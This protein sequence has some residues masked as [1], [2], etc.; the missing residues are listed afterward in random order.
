MHR[1]PE[2]SPY[3]AV[4]RESIIGTSGQASERQS[5]WPENGARLLSLLAIAI[6]ITCLFGWIYDIDMLK[7]VGAGLNS[8]KINT[9]IGVIIAGFAQ[10]AWG[11]AQNRAG[12][13]SRHSVKK[14]GRLGVI[15][16]CC[17]AIIAM[18]TLLEYLL[19][20]DFGIDNLWIVD[21]E[22]MSGPFPGRM[23]VAT[24]IALLA[25]ALTLIT[26]RTAFVWVALGI[27]GFALICYLLDLHSIA[28]L[29]VANMAIHTSIA[30][31]LLSAGRIMAQP[32]RGM[33]QLLL[34][35][36]LGGAMARVMLPVAILAP[37]AV[38]W[39][40]GISQR[41]GLLD[42]YLSS[43][44]G[45]IL[46]II[47]L[48]TMVFMTGRA[49]TVI[50]Q[51]RRCAELELRL[52]HNALEAKVRERTEELRQ[53]RDEANGANRHKSVFLAHMSHELRTPLNAILGF[54][55]IMRREQFG[56]MGQR[57]YVSYADDIH[58][59]GSHLL[60]LINDI[61]DLSKIEAGKFDFCPQPILAGSIVQA[62]HDLI[63]GLAKE[64][65]LHLRIEVPADLPS[66]EADKRAIKQILIN[67]LSNAIKF[68]PPGGTVRLAVEG[69][70]DGNPAGRL[71]HLV[72]IVQDTGIGM[73]PPEIAAAQQ[74]FGQIRN[75]FSRSHKGTGLGLFLAKQLTELQAGHLE[76][77][78]MPGLGTT[79]RVGLPL[80][81]AT[82]IH[83]SAER[84]RA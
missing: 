1:R 16:G 51:R 4:A 57:R 36:D 77:D 63:V 69:Q 21:L 5:A 28:R 23:P 2:P 52:S 15:L 59:S 75:Q 48:T 38:S 60:S 19:G 11:Q 35:E 24:A 72:F 39:L 76:I 6:A 65:N 3:V 44:L 37:V 31:I 22:P 13:A 83:V 82:G 45:A 7:C 70:N 8:M 32:N 67:L 17:L 10:I 58:H 9:A 34:A 27:A 18:L 71:S 42:G 46:G 61:L 54:A 74:P 40:A 73:S 12:R 14:A 66:I 43:A 26:D 78:S 64:R 53:A 80:Q 20:I 68:T 55:D 33:M 25:F 47:L 62:C 41:I 49:L 84:S 79:I 56:A 29:A 30:L 81:P 50:D